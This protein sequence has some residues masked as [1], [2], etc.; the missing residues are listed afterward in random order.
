MDGFL[1]DLRTSDLTRVDKGKLAEQ[2][3]TR[4]RKDAGTTLRRRRMLTEQDI[5]LLVQKKSRESWKNPPR[6]SHDA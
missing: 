2:S 4:N 1:F 6:R 3:K 5:N